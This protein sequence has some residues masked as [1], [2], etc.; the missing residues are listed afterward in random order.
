MSPSTA[1][2]PAGWDK[3]LIPIC[4]PNTNGATGWC[5]ET[6]D[7][8]VAKYAAG[9]PKDL[10]YTRD[11]RE[12]GLLDPQTLDERLRD[13]RLK[14]TDKPR[15]WI[16]STLRR[17]R[18]LHD[19]GRHRPRGTARLQREDPGEGRRRT[20]Q[21]HSPGDQVDRRKTARGPRFRHRRRPKPKQPSGTF[22]AAASALPRKRWSTRSPPNGCKRAIEAVVAG[23]RRRVPAMP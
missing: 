7:I 10:R 5:I 2:L 12:N 15:D 9:R 21:R 17:Q 11:L 20:T 6:H 22:S 16:E 8:A 1:S 19:T 14:P 4:N 13:T 18:A 23:G 3:R